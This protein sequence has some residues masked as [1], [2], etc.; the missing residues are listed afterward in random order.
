MLIDTHAHLDIEEF[1][2]DR[3]AVIAAA[4]AAGVG[5]IVCPA[6][7]ADSSAAVVQLA[8]EHPQVF[9]AVGIQPNYCAAAAADAWD[10]VAALARGQRV[11]AVGETGL[12]RHWDYTPF[13][14]QQDYFD[15]HL[16]LAQ[17]L[18]LPVIVHCR[19]ADADVLAMLHEAA[20]RGRLAGVLHSF[21]GDQ[22]MA[23]ACLELGL[24]LSFSGAVTYRNR[25]FDALR[26]VAAAAPAE[27]ILIETDSPY[28]APEPLRGRTQRNEPAHLVHT[29]A[30]L[31]ALR[32]VAPE[33]LAAETTANAR[34]LFS[35]CAR[36]P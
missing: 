28:L 5:V 33:T 17:S 22:A 34:R 8:A 19:E 27:R 36:C 11:V 21:S 31:A 1:A 3:A 7:S 25:K 12:D 6:I 15:R 2:A 23:E 20:T 29:A 24:Y 26:A 9:A 14:V 30:R 18:G 4:R 32:G 35:V 16:R 10:R 13:A